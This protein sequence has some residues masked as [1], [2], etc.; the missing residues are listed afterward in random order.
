MIKKR[1]LSPVV[2][3]V[4]LV[5]IVIVIALIVFFWF[6]GFTQE[7]ITK[8]DNT[9]VQL[10]CDQVSFTGDFSGGV[11]SISNDGNVPIFQVKAKVLNA[12]SYTTVT[13]GEGDVSWPKNGLNQGDAYQG[14]LSGVTVSPGDRI[15][16][17]PVLLGNTAS[18]GKKTYTCEDRQGKEI[19]A[20]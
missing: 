12:G 17:I 18:N 4:L 2:A 10:V 5:S 14:T 8:F 19:F 20:V 9:N 3:T 1:G 16:L 11:L 13:V 6:K 7:A 15:I